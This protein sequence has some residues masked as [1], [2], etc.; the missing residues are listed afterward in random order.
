MTEIAAC[1]ALLAMT[2]AVGSWLIV[3]EQDG[4]R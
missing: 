4:D 1:I 2:L 3:H